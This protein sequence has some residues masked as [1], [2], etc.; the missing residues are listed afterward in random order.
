MGFHDLMIFQQI[1]QGPLPDNQL[2]YSAE[3][4][5]PL[6]CSIFFANLG[7]MKD[8]R[9]YLITHCLTC[10][11]TQLYCV[12]KQ[13]IEFFQKVERKSLCRQKSQNVVRKS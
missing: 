10:A 5:Y 8:C 9:S 11:P 2:L 3:L 12:L 7:Q 4:A 1:K 6:I 13:I